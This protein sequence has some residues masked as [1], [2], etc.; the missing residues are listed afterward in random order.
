MELSEEAF[1]Q[2]FANLSEADKKLLL[3]FTQQLP[4]AKAAPIASATP[5]PDLTKKSL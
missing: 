5:P 2:A 3:E 1:A 4:S